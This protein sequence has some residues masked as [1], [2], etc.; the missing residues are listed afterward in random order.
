MDMSLCAT[1]HAPTAGLHAAFGAG[2]AGQQANL[3]RACP[4]AQ[5]ASLAAQVSSLKVEEPA[6]ALGEEAAA[7]PANGTAEA[8]AAATEPAGSTLVA[9]DEA[10]PGTKA[11]PAVA[12]G[13]DVQVGA[14]HAPRLALHAPLSHVVPGLQYGSVLMVDAVGCAAGWR[15]ALW[16][17][18]L[19]GRGWQPAVADASNVDDAGQSRMQPTNRSCICHQPQCAGVHAAVAGS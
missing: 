4:A 15:P 11:M 6:P 10:A 5:E 13:S 12:A 16:Q 18:G 17:A 14:L 19:G 7:A 2:P 1:W 3:P 9:E 8:A